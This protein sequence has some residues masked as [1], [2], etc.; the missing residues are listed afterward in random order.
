MLTHHTLCLTCFENA[1]LKAV[2][3]PTGR[4]EL[5]KKHSYFICTAK[6]S[7]YLLT[8]TKSFGSFMKRLDREP[9][10]SLNRLPYPP[11]RS[12][13]CM[14]NFG[15]PDTFSSYFYHFFLTSNINV[16]C[17]SLEDLHKNVFKSILEFEQIVLHQKGVAPA[18]PPPA[19]TGTRSA[20]SIIATLAD[21]FW[22]FIL[23]LN[24]EKL[25]ELES[26]EKF[27]VAF[28]MWLEAVAPG[29]ITS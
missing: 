8:T 9:L 18:P 11:S 16:S 5:Q 29:I 2:D 4:P 6:P 14:Q 17:S 1:L 7:Q 22:T 13:R 26:I 20:T 12:P 25:V 24:E 23:T 19:L 27:S 28:E 10:Q 15:L 21:S 3:S